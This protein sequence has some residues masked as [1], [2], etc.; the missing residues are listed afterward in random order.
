[1][2]QSALIRGLIA[3]V[4][5]LLVYPTSD[6][7]AQDVRA[8]NVRAQDQQGVFT[9]SG[10]PVDGQGDDQGWRHSRRPSAGARAWR[11]LALR[12][13]TCRVPPAVSAIGDE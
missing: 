7:L 10:I 8:P 3:A 13:T 9:V 1:M 11:P 2:L 4:A 12:K 6:G 5:I